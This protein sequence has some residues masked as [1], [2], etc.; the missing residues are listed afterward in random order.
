MDSR[1][2]QLGTIHIL[3]H[4]ITESPPQKSSPHPHMTPVTMLP[5]SL[6]P[7]THDTPETHLYLYDTNKTQNFSPKPPPQNICHSPLP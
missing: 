6:P 5:S 4:Q 2:T 3:Q 7:V 1:G